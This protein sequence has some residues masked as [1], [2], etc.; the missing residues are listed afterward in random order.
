MSA[1]RALR[2][3]ERNAASGDKGSIQSF[4]ALSTDGSNADKAAVHCGRITIDLING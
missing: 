1:L 3:F 4:A 2:Q